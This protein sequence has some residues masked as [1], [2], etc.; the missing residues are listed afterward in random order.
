MEQMS[1]NF[2]EGKYISSVDVAKMIGKEHRNLLRDIQKYSEAIRNAGQL[3]FELSDFFIKTTY[4]SPQN[5]KLV[6]YNT[7]KRGC[8]FI[9]NKL[10]G[11]KGAL[12]TAAYTTRFDEMVKQLSSQDTDIK[13]VV[14][15]F[16]IPTTLEGAY[17]LL[18]DYERSKNKLVEKNKV[19]VAESNHFKNL[20]EE[21]IPKAQ[22]LDILTDS[23]SF[24]SVD[25]VAKM[26]TF[27][28][29]GQR[30]LFAFLIKTKVLIDSYTPYQRYVSNRCVKIFRSSGVNDY[31]HRY[32][33]QQVKF[34]QKGVNMIIRLL[35]K[36]GYRSI[37][38]ELLK[39][40]PAMNKYLN[41]NGIVL[42]A[43]NNPIRYDPDRSA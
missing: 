38:P 23:S 1:L 5:K 15:K 2:Y 30:K 4:L 26:I 16:S 39:D 8:D 12:F 3:N 21:L 43:Y 41:L 25:E 34:T 29:M 10:T 40:Y 42:T 37:H 35:L 24:F 28:C 18:A 11:K 19:L 9:A 20:N 13:S 14:K 7:T 36:Y 27:E 22:A 32:N 6:C 33:G 17:L 31:G